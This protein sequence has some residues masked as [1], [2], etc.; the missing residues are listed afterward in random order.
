MWVNIGAQQ[1]HLP[2]MSAPNVLHG[3]TAIE[4][5]DWVGTAASCFSLFKRNW[6]S[7]FVAQDAL[8]DRLREAERKQLFAETKFAY[9]VDTVAGHLRVTEPYGNVFVAD[10][11]VAPTPHRLGIRAIEVFVRPGTAMRIGLF[12]AAVL[13]AIVD[14]SDAAC[15]VVCGAAFPYLPWGV[16]LSRIACP[17][18]T[19]PFC[20]LHFRESADAAAHAY[21]GWHVAIYLADYSGPYARC[22]A[23]GLV[24]NNPR[25]VDRVYSFDDALRESQFRFKDIID[26]E[27]GERL[28]EMEHEVRSLAHPYFMRPF[29]NRLHHRT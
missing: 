9:S 23:R 21:D 14:T 20:R 1:F 28:L 4:V 11:H 15:A 18:H 27:T 16:G 26:L 13:G 7:L 19:G 8:L 25:F 12:Y 29:V 3:H 10:R 17:S 5:P 6:G 24:W 22:A 2:V